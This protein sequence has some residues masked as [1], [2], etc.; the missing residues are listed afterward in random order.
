MHPATAYSKALRV[1]VA[2]SVFAFIPSLVSAQKKS[3]GG[4]APAPKAAPPK[5][6]AKPAAPAAKPGTPAA[7]PGTPAARPGAPAARP[8]TPGATKPGAPGSRP[9]TPGAATKPGTPGS[10]PATPA[11]GKPATPAAKPG[12]VKNADGTSTRTNANGST[13][14]LGKNGKPTGVTTA[15]GTKA[16]LNSSGHV[17]SVNKS[18]TDPKNPMHSGTMT[19]NHGSHGAKSVV[20]QRKDGSRLVSNGAHRGYVEHTFNRGGHPYM[21]RTYVV[22]GH[23][24]AAVYRGYPYRGGVYYGYVPGYYY[25]P[26]FYGWAYEPWGAPFAYGWGWGADPWFGFYGGFFTPFAAY[27][28]ASLWLTDYAIAEN[29]Q[30]AYQ[31]QLDA[32]GGNPPP[33]T[34]QGGDA[35]GGAA[36]QTVAMTPEVKQAIA[37]EV[38]AQLAAEKAAAAPNAPPP[39]AD[40][41]PAALDPSVRTFI[42]ANALAET[43]P[44]GSSCS[45]SQGDVL[46]RLS[47]DPDAN[48]NINVL[49]TSSQSG[50]CTAGAQV[51]VGVQDLQDMHNEFA[52]KIDAGLQKLADNEGK[53]GIPTGPAAGQQKNADGQAAPDLTA[54]ADLQQQQQDA[55]AAEADVK[56][57]TTQ[58]SD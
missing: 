43:L 31:A 33:A 15:N 45:L 58:G 47:T 5:P 34:D 17:T 2:V 36:P 11:A 7:K 25:S 42:V 1:L 14:T 48:S 6:A 21:R 8:G 10:K 13:T 18:V 24:Y 52:Q 32:N 50:D 53:G 29:L 51:P 23:A 16:N 38:K 26:G 30:A 19:V 20:T 4:S 27:A 3:S 9:A 41:P 57:G 46:T 49:V 56:A 39:P 22:N 12:T 40:Q 44:D 28:D 54:T 37:D 35:S 55:S